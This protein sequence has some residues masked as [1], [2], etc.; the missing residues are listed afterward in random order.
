MFSIV[1]GTETKPSADDDEIRKFEQ[2]SDITLST[3]A[4]LIQ[5]Y[6]YFAPVMELTNPKEVW[7]VMTKHYKTVR[8]ASRDAFLDKYQA[9]KCNLRKPYSSFVHVFMI[10]NPS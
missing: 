10:N 4:L 7:D 5:Y 6:S 3:I 2:R 1:Q 9:L 8:Q